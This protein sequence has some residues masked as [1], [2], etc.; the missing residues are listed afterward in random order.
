VPL[1]EIVLAEQFIENS[2]CKLTEIR[3]SEFG[4]VGRENCVERLHD[5]CQLLKVKTNRG[6]AMIAAAKNSA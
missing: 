6:D 4:R 1:S 5:I 2:P 3:F